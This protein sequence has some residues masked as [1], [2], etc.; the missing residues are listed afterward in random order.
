M[1]KSDRTPKRVVDLFTEPRLQFSFVPPYGSFLNLKGVAK[2]LNPADYKL[3]SYLRVNSSTWWVKPYLNPSKT[4]IKADGSW[5]I[6]MTTGGVDSTALEYIVYL[7]NPDYV[8][9]LHI[10]PV[11]G[12]YIT[13]I[14]V[15]R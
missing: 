12:Q 15:V 14:R 11:E 7:I 3:T 4:T 2:N 6:D 1:F 9:D 8:P 5:E 13:K 10:L